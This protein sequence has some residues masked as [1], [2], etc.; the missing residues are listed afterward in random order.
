LVAA[1][2]VV[3]IVQMGRRSVL[4]GRRAAPEPLGLCHTPVDAAPSGSRWDTS[5]ESRPSTTTYARVL[6]RVTQ[7]GRP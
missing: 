5:I 6:Q 7:L 2:L 3:E 4:H 1:G